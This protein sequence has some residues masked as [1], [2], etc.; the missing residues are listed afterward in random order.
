M[1]ETQFEDEV[2]AFLERRRE[3]RERAY[4]SVTID[5]QFY[6]LLDWSS[7]GFLVEG[8]GGGLRKGDRVK[9]EFDV[10]ID[11]DTYF[12]RCGAIIVRAD[13]ETGH[14]AGAFVDM[15]QEDRLAVAQC[16]E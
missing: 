2:E 7:S 11:G 10:R 3:G 9:I 12:F 6:Q 8:F 16:F 5:E 15:K 13:A 1:I 4:G 14:L